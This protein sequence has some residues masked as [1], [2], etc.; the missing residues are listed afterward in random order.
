[1]M[2]E[3]EDGDEGVGEAGRSALAVYAVVLVATDHVVRAT[4]RHSNR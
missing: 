1:M 3:D 2:V 4:S